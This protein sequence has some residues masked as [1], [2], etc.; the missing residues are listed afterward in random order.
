MA[1]ID[2]HGQRVEWQ[3]YRIYRARNHIVH[4]GDVPSFLDSLVL[5]AAEYY[6]AALTTIINRAHRQEDRSDVDQVVAEI[7]IEYHMF[8]RYFEAR[9]SQQRLSRD[10]LLRLVA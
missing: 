8:L 2:G 3:I 9:R 10:D 7:G 4:A 5:N 1:A 6:T